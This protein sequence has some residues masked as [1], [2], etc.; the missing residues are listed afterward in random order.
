M[1]LDSNGKSLTPPEPR[2]TWQEQLERKKRQQRRLG[3]IAFAV[4]AGIII[5]CSVLFTRGGGS[6]TTKTYASYGGAYDGQT[7]GVVFYVTSD[8]PY[9]V[10]DE[11]KLKE[12]LKSFLLITY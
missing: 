2:K 12:D 4:V 7:P 8:S 5:V 9:N 1:D 11:Q 10:G 6:E 3:A